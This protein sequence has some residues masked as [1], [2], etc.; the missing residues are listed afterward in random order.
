MHRFVWIA[1]VPGVT[2]GA[3]KSGFAPFRGSES[4]LLKA[5]SAEVA[6]AFRVGDSNR[7]VTV[8]RAKPAFFRSVSHE[9]HI[10]RGM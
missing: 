10:S 4:S 5:Q 1:L 6:I 7:A 3:A 2:I 8:D 9:F